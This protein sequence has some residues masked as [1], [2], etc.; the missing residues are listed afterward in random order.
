MI[1]IFPKNQ[2][3]DYTFVRQDGMPRRHGNHER[4]PPNRHSG[5]IGNRKKT[6]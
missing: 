1:K 4:I 6:A 2:Y 3:S 5:D